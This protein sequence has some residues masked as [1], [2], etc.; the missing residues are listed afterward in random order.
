MAEVAKVKKVAEVAEG[1]QKCGR[2]E[3][4]TRL[5]QEGDPT[6]EDEKVGEVTQLLGLHTGLDADQGY[7]W[8][9]SWGRV[10]R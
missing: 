2:H 9:V 3:G 5:L 8:R 7:N 1:G 10:S 4:H 6:E